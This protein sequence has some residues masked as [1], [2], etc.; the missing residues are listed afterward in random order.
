MNIFIP[1]K[2]IS[3]RVPNKNFR[4]FNGEPLYKHTLLKFLDCNVFVDTD[5]EEIKNNINSDPRLKN[6]KVIERKYHLLGHETSVC[7]LIKDFIESFKIH[8]PIVQLH[9]TSPFLKRQTI[10]NAY[11]LISSF[12]SILSCNVHQTRF[13]RKEQYGFCPINHNPADMQQ[14]QNL[15]KYYEENSTFYIFDPHVFLSINARVGK[16]AYFYE[17]SEPENLDIDTEKDWRK[18]LEYS[19]L[20]TQEA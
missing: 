13:W 15:P 5:S 19:K 1:I 20:Y 4:I 17:L 14:T 18:C 10:N 2:H 16:N 6:V 7:L 3:Q 11:S 8:E 9:V 12:D